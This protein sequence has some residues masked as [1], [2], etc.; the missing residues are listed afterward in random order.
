[1]LV[2][3]SLTDDHDELEYNRIRV[4]GEGDEI[5]VA[6]RI[7]GKGGMEGSIDFWNRGGP[8]ESGIK[9]IT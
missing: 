8:R 5:G 1:M 3:F 2:F 6:T 4:I 9:D 7:I